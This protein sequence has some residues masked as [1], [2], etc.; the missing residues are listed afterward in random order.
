[1][2][3]GMP[4]SGPVRSPLALRAI[5]RT[6][7]RQRV[8][9]IEMGESLDFALDSRDPLEAGARIVFGRN[10]AA[11]DFGEACAAVEPIMPVSAVMPSPTP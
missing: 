4:C 6:R 11:R 3:T 5:E 2:P 9:R 10:R 8:L 1:M 7:L